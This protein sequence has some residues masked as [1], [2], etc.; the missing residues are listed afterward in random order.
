M[1]GEIE[2]T[3]EEHIASMRT[4]I[5]LNSKRLDKLEDKLT[6]LPNM[7]IISGLALLLGLFSGVWYLSSELASMK[8]TLNMHMQLSK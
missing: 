1:E 5:L 7:L 3:P 2:R 6:T 8:T 4:Q